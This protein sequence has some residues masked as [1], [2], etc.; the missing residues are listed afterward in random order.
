MLKR[1]VY[2]HTFINFVSPWKSTHTTS[3]EIPQFWPVSADRRGRETNV[4]G[5]NV[6]WMWGSDSY[7]AE[8]ATRKQLV[9]NI[10]CFGPFQTFPPQSFFSKCVCVCECIENFKLFVY[11]NVYVVN[12][13]CVCIM[14]LCVRVLKAF[15]VWLC[16]CS[17]TFNCFAACGSETFLLFV[18]RSKCC[19]F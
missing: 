4:S 2:V 11:K 15:Y 1:F 8:R 3:R 7:F 17:P 19:C 5:R 6:G 13:L 18:H 12:W 14:W 9:W 10:V 16:V